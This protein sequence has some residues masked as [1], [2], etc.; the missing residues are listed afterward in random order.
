MYHLIIFSDIKI[1]LVLNVHTYA[2]KTKKAEKQ[3]K[4]TKNYISKKDDVFIFTSST[5]SIE[6]NITYYCDQKVK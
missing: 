4:P 3:Q 5:S 1:L 2:Y 6:K